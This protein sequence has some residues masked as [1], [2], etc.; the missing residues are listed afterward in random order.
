M[1]ARSSSLL[2]A[3]AL[4]ACSEPS[5]PTCATQ[6]A[7]EV[8]ATPGQLRGAE[9]VQVTVAESVAIAFP[10]AP[11]VEGRYV[12]VASREL[13]PEGAPGQGGARLQGVLELSGCVLRR[14]L[15]AEGAPARVDVFELSYEGSALRLEQRCPEQA[16]SLEAGFGFDGERLELGPLWPIAGAP[17][18][19]CD[20]LEL[21]ELR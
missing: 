14:T 12:L 21:W 20:T 8:C 17:E 2:A 9:P 6:I 7:A 10:V 4:G 19:S 5:V 1:S 11:L 18:P 13:C 3:L 15:V 16:G